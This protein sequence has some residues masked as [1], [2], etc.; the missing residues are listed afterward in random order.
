MMKNII[1]LIMIKYSSRDGLTSTLESFSF[2]GL[3]LIV[4]KQSLLLH[5]KYET[6]FYLRS[7][8]HSLL[9]NNRFCLYQQNKMEVYLKGLYKQLLLCSSSHI[10][11]RKV[12][13]LKFQEP[14]SLEFHKMCQQATLH[15]VMQ[16]NQ[17][18]RFLLN[19][20]RVLLI[21]IFSSLIS[22]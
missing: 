22:R 11:F 17:N 8:I 1:V 18:L 21:K 20:F 5:Q 4:Y 13:H 16:P 2:Q 7:Y 10:P 9:F 12:S 3:T 15:E 19:K 6:N 14:H